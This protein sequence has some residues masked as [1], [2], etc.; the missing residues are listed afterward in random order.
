[1]RPLLVAFL[2]ASLSAPPFFAQSQKKMIEVED[3]DL[4]LLRDAA[5][6]RVVRRV[7]GTVRVVFNAQERWIIVLVD[8]VTPTKP[9]DGRVDLT[10]NASRVEGEWPLGARWEGR[11]TVDDYSIA[12]ELGMIGLGINTGSAFVQ[13]LATGPGPRDAR[14]IFRDPSAAAMVTF[15]GGGRGSGG[16]ETLDQ[17]EQRQAT[18][19]SRN[20]AGLPPSGL[21]TSESLSFTGGASGGVVRGVVGGV[22]GSASGASGYPAPGAPVRVGG[23]IKTPARI[24]DAQPVMP[25]IAQQAGVRG[26]VILEIIIAA[27]GQVSDAKVLR[28]IPLLDAAAIE[29]ARKWRYEPTL[30]NGAPVPVIMT[31]TVSFQ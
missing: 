15:S 31:A 6:V 20:A 4:I 8:Q 23:T 2:L 29:A 13:L 16:N 1:M 24:V 28:S 27:D 5:R 17:A 11:A 26:V 22:V 18:T 19:A 10:F 21:A 7:E 30:L 12:T 14:V 3:G 25:A 9:A